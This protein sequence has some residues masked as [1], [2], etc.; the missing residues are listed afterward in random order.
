MEFVTAYGPKSKVRKDFKE[1]SMTKQSFKKEA[2]VNVIISRFQKTGAVEHL[3]RYQ[4]QY[5]DLQAIDYHQAMN[6]VLAAQE[7]FETVPSSVRKQFGND[8]QAFLDYAT[9]PA[10]LDKMREWGLA[11]PDVDASPTAAAQAA[12]GE[13]EPMPTGGDQVAP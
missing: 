3:N 1:P 6:A 4:G 13:A 11:Y 5:A 7:M 12:A 9:D 10:N 8:P 2:D